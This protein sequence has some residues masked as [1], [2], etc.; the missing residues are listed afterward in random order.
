[1]MPSSNPTFVPK[2]LPIVAFGRGKMLFPLGVFLAILT[3]F[4]SQAVANTFTTIDFPGAISPGTYTWSINNSG[5]V[6]GYYYDSSGFL[7][8]FSYSGGSHSTIDVPVPG[9]TYTTAFGINNSGEITGT[10]GDAFGDHV[11][12]DKGGVF[13]Y[14]SAPAEVNGDSINDSGEIAGT[15]N[16]AGAAEHGF[17]NDG[18][19]VTTIDAPGASQT[20]VYAIGKSG[21]LLGFYRI[22][23]TDQGFIDT[24]GSFLPINATF[25]GTIATYPGGINGSGEIVGAYLDGSGYH[26]FLDNG[27]SS[28]P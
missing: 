10:Y 15:Y 18:G 25:P 2:G 13:S 23:S 9:A 5:E 16:D 24:G 3:C 26:G 28:Q 17:V 4:S 7:H 8:G 27:G 20:W 6:V 14:P 21:Q 11:Y 1:M 19:T 12:V 22:G